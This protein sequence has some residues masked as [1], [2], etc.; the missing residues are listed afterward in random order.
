MTTAEVSLHVIRG[1][2]MDRKEQLQ[3]VHVNK[4]TGYGRINKT[5][6]LWLQDS[7]G[8]EHRYQGDLFD[9]AR[10]G[11][12]VAVFSDRASGKLVA[13][14]NLTTQRIH[15]AASLNI[16]TTFGAN[17]FSTFGL[18]F[19]LALPGLFPWYM[20]MDAIGLSGRAFSAT[21]LQIYIVMLL[22]CVFV[23]LKIWT[24]RYEERTA[25]LKAE[26]DRV[27]GLDA[28]STTSCK[29]PPE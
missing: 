13:V 22:V 2:V 9:A 4:T 14:A 7:A 26:V 15:E 17:L 1:V 27:L 23:G 24:K 18:G 21:S 8:C 10:P 6:E 5:T 16:N 29:R 20:I 12:E 3:S 25:R 11:H 28:S 19:L